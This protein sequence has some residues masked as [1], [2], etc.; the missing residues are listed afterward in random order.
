MNLLFSLI[1][2]SIVG[3]TVVFALLLLRPITGKVFSKA[4]HYYCLIVPLV[5]LLGGTHM[6]ISLTGLMSR[7][8]SIDTL[9]MPTPQE[10]SSGIQHDFFRPTLS[11]NLLPVWSGE[12]YADYAT[13]SSSF[14]SQTLMLFERISP[15]LVFIWVLGVILFIVVSTTK[16]LQYRRKVLHSAKAV[17]DI[18][19]K[20]PIIM[21]SAVHTPM[22]LGVIKPIIVLPNMHFADEELH[23]ILAHEMV[24]Y[25]RKDLLVKLLMLIANAVHWFNPA[26]Y[27]LNRQLNAMCELSC[28]EKVVSEMDSQ[29]RKL[30]GET[31]LQVVKHGTTHRNLAGSIVFATNLCSAKKN[32]K[33]RLISMMNAKKMK[34][35][36][37][38]LAVAVGLLVVGGGFVLANTIGSAMPVMS[39]YANQSDLPSTS[40]ASTQA[41]FNID[42]YDFI[43]DVLSVDVISAE[44]AAQ[45]AADIL[46][47]VFNADLDGITMQLYYSRDEWP[48]SWSGVHRPDDNSMVKFHF[49]VHAETGEL[50][51]V[52]YNP[53]GDE[54]LDI[55]DFNVL[56]EI[57]TS[58]Q[59]NIEFASLAMDIVQANNILEGAPAR[60]RLISPLSTSPARTTGDPAMKL[61]MVTVQCINGG[62]AL[63]SF[64]SFLGGDPLL[65]SI[66][67]EAD[68][69]WKYWY[70]FQ[71]DWV[72]R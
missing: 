63:M 25:R 38:A 11:D 48:H 69:S 67:I 30:Y 21:S 71:T 42:V 58:A 34:K 2:S 6:T 72:S 60:A 20:I 27:A 50:I 35:A 51:S 62:V 68:Y 15:Y 53:W 18:D 45:I 13:S 22:L 59:Q 4:W 61:A 46:S 8:S 44:V 26:V 12:L 33:R 66:T 17:T 10:I 24:H 19:C 57:E 36:V 54:I 40:S 41:Q 56:S 65:T 52:H 31:I 29:N 7:T 43:N 16:Y 64:Y 1:I 49:N 37:M 32:I 47:C 5:F 55:V 39:V 28:D 70:P 9:L 3:S 23:M 14:A